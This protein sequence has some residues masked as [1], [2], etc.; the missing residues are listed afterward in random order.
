MCLPYSKSSTDRSLRM[1][2]SMKRIGSS[3]MAS[4][5]S[6]LK[7][8]KRSR[9]TELF[10]LEAPEIQPVAA[11]LD[12]ETARPLV[13]QHAPGLR[14][15]ERRASRRSPA[16]ACASNSSSGMLRP[17]EIAQPARQRIGDKGCVCRPAA[18]VSVAGASC[19]IPQHRGCRSLPV[20]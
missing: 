4:R 19:D 14:R 12:G 7:A 10:V 11:E 17:E 2:S 16:A 20:D 8:G 3:N 9:S 1:T 15:A 6:L 5:S 18:D 13:F